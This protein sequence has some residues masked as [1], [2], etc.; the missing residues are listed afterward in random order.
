M[1]GRR[2]RAIKGV[3][4]M[5]L[6]RDRVGSEQITGTGGRRMLGQ[7]IRANISL[8]HIVHRSELSVVFIIARVAVGGRE[9]GEH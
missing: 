7:K 2:T 3:R 6:V 1:S 5:E 9:L 8:L 4:L